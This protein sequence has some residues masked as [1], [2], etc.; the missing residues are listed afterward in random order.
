[1]LYFEISYRGTEFQMQAK[2]LGYWKPISEEE[3][4]EL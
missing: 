1:M 2:T 4:E 3:A